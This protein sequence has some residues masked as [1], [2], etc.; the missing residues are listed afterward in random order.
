[1]LIVVRFAGLDLAL[2]QASGSISS[3]RQQVASTRLL[4]G[5]SFYPAL[6]VLLRIIVLRPAL[7][8][9]IGA[10]RERNLGT[11]MGGGGVGTCALLRAR[12]RNFTVGHGRSRMT[13]DERG[14]SCMSEASPV[15]SLRY[16]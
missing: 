6:V 5:C 8:K 2:L 10:D 7:A 11:R 9:H 14:S 3:C 13:R 4:H 12:E 1:M 15:G 16:F